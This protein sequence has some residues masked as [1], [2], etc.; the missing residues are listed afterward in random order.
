MIDRDVRQV[1]TG[2]DGLVERGRLRDVRVGQQ[3]GAQRRDLD[4]RPQVLPSSLEI[5]AA[6]KNCC[7]V[8]C[9]PEPWNNTAPTLTRR[10]LKNPVAPD[11]A[12]WDGCDG[13]CS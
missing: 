1:V 8:G 2:P 11:A 6:Q 9:T 12:I 13:C 4:R 7:G 10:A 5:I 3:R